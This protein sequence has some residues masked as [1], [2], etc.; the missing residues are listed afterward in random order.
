MNKV[1]SYRDLEVW[2]RAVN[3]SVQLYQVTEEFPKSE[4]YG[5]TNQMRRASVS[6]ASNI[7]EGHGRS[8][9]EFGRYLFIARGS[10][11]ELETQMEIAK[12]I[13]YLKESTYVQMTEESNILGKQ[14]NVL[15]QRVTG[16]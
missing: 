6:I 13:G 9:P 2:Q 11:A 4:Q 5:L 14:L 7:A 12:R 16:R 1:K 15:S 10:L 8:D 3:F